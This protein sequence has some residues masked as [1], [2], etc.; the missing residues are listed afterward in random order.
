MDWGRLLPGY[1]LQNFPT[2]LVWDEFVSKA[3]DEDRVKA[4]S[5]HY[6]A[7]GGMRV[8]IENYPYAY[9]RPVG[10]AGLS[11]ILPTVKTRKKLRAALMDM[12]LKQL[13]GQL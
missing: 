6:A 7:I 2:N 3:I 8:W 9:G 10:V 5:Q 1:W 13:L 12:A 11:N 4:I